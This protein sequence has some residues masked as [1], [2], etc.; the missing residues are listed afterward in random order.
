MQPLKNVPKIKISP[1]EA[2]PSESRLVQVV[3]GWNSVE[4]SRTRLD[5]LTPLASVKAV[6]LVETGQLAFCRSSMPP[7]VALCQEVKAISDMVPLC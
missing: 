2:A 5:A 3:S 1:W 6:A 7:S 4:L